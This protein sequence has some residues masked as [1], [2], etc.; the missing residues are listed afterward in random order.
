MTYKAFRQWNT[1]IDT[2]TAY[3]Q[4]PAFK[5]EQNNII[6]MQMTLWLVFV[7]MKSYW[8]HEPAHSPIQYSQ[9][10]FEQDIL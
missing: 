4:Y 9:V 6:S 3:L 5:Q 7:C 8:A 2:T 1:F 10:L